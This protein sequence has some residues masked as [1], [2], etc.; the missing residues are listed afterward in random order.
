MLTGSGPANLT[1]A[2]LEFKESSSCS[3]KMPQLVL[4]TCWNPKQVDSNDS[5]ETDLVVR[6]EQAGKE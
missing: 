2:G 3:V 4:N 1:M 6:Q 5:E